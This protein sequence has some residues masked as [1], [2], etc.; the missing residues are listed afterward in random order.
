MKVQINSSRKIIISIAIIIT[1]S[2]LT[3]NSLAQTVKVHKQFITIWQTDQSN[4]FLV[5]GQPGAIEGDSETEV[6]IENKNSGEKIPVKLNTDGSFTQTIKADTKDQL[7]VWAQNAQDRK[8]YGSFYITSA[9]QIPPEPKTQAKALLSSSQM[10][11]NRWPESKTVNNS[12]QTQQLAFIVNVIDLNTGEIIEAR[13]IA[14]K[15]CYSTDQK[16]RIHALTGKVL[17]QCTE[18][19]QTEFQKPDNNNTEINKTDD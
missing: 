12:G 6:Y 15:T 11:V 10:Q 17:N 2:L 4:S 19:I 18:I 5:Q 3:I 8:S 14:G 13:R 9:K 16:T 7:R 1:G